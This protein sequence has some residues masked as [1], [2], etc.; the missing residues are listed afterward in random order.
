M[1]LIIVLN[2][3]WIENYLLGIE[4]SLYRQSP[5]QM[6]V[7]ALISAYS[8][9]SHSISE[10][11]KPFWW[12]GFA[13]TTRQLYT[14]LK[15]Q[16]LYNNGNGRTG[17]RKL[18]TYSG[19]WPVFMQIPYIWMYNRIEYWY[20]FR[21]PMRPSRHFTHTNSLRFISPFSYSL[22]L[23]SCHMDG[24]EPCDSGHSRALTRGVD[25]LRIRA[26]YC[27]KFQAWVWQVLFLHVIW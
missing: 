5:I 19:F 1:W 10:P 4:T 9:F 24:S 17:V 25:D 16:Q 27:K 26:D 22:S 15:S 12:V 3:R 21:A 6:S 18:F 20:S 2:E 11:V 14:G 23:F 13:A 7:S 8:S